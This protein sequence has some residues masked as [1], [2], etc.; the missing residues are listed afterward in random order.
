MQMAE[1]STEPKAEFMHSPVLTQL[2]NLEWKQET[3][4]SNVL[5]ERY[6]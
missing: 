1:D 2:H 3:Y 6:A 4:W 5:M